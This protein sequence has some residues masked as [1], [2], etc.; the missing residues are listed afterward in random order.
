MKAVLYFRPNLA[1][2]KVEDS[3]KIEVLPGAL[4]RTDHFPSICSDESVVQVPL[5]ICSFEVP[6]GAK[7][8]YKYQMITIT[9][10]SEKCRYI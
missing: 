1:H 8:E 3:I 2:L 7:V 4:L 10:H 6:I 9:L 5:Y